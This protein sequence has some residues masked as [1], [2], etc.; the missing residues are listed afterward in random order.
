M[1]LLSSL[2]LGLHQPEG[3]ASREDSLPFLLQGVSNSTFA[4]AQAALLEASYSCS[5]HIAGSLVGPSTD[6]TVIGG[7]EKRQW[8]GMD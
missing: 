7:D 4:A 6:V 3:L 1:T 8:G 5:R 2:E